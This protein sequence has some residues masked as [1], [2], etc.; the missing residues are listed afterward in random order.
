MNTATKTATYTDVDIRD[1]VRQLRTDLYMI[2][3]STGT[4]TRQQVQNYVHDVELLALGDYLAWVDVTLLSDGQE[5]KAVRYK[6]DADAG[7]LKVSRPGGV[8]WPKTPSATLRMII[9]YSIQYDEAAQSQLRDK[10]KIS[11]GPSND[12]TSHS[13]LSAGAGRNYASNSYGLQRKN[14]SQ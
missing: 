2:A 3:E 11:W 7:S 4:W 9:S 14:W 1:V 5:V 10:L 8:L 13:S 6:V 12:D